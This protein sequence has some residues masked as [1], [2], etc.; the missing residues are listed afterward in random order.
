MEYGLRILLTEFG[1]FIEGHIE[2]ART[3]SLQAGGPYQLEINSFC[4]L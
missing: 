1:K 4:T 3:H 2:A